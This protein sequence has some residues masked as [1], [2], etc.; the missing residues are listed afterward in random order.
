MRAL[1]IAMSLLLSVGAIAQTA[2]TRLWFTYDASES[3]CFEVPGPAARIKELR[4]MQRQNIETKDYGDPAN[5]SKVDVRHISGRQIITNTY[6]R[7]KETCEAE[8]PRNLPIP[9]RYR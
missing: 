5:P 4:D 3:M 7:S 1:P 2:S 8:L 9:D 6:W